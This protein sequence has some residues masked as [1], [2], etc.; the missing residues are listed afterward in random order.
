MPNYTLDTDSRTLT[1]NGDILWSTYTAWSSYPSWTQHTSTTT[2]AET[3][4]TG[5]PLYFQTEIIDLGSSLTVYPEINYSGQGDVRAVIEFSDNSD[6]SSASFLGKYTTDNAKDTEIVVYDVLDYQEAG[7]TNED[8]STNSN[9]SSFTARYVRFTAF[10]EDFNEAST[11]R[12]V[13]TLESFN[14]ALKTDIISETL[15]DVAVSGDTAALTFADIGSVISMNITPHSVSN[16]KLIGQIVN[17]TN[18]TIR[19]VDANSFSVSGVSATVDVSATGVPGKLE[20]STEG[21]GKI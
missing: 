10:V 11:S 13:Q 21:V 8:S 17:K 16:K 3:G 2:N 9:Y 20:A 12:D 5:T 1:H 6:L 19:V 18:K 15:Q 7:Y 14:W 4:A